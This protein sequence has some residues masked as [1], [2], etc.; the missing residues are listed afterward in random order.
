MRKINQKN[1]EMIIIGVI[2]L[3]AF[4]FGFLSVGILKSFIVIG[5]ADLIYLSTILFNKKKNKPNTYKNNINQ[6]HVKKE[7]K[8]KSKKKIWKIIAIIFLILCIA[9]M[10]MVCGFI[11]YI[12]DN[13]PKFDPEELYTQES[14][15]LYA[16]DGSVIAKL[17]AEKR[18]KVTYDQLPEVLI[19]SIVATEDARFFQH[20]GFDLSR[21]VIAS[22]KQVLTGGGGGA[23]T[24]TMQVSK[25]TYTSTESSGIEG[26]IRKFTDIYLSIFQIEKNYS[27]EEIMEFYVNAPYLGGGSYGVEQACQTYFNKSVS[28]INLAEAAMIAGLFQA[29]NAYDP[30]LHPEATE[31]RRQTVLYLMKRHGYITDEEYEIAK[32]MTVEKLLS[33]STDDESS[34]NDY[35]AFIDTV[36]EEVIDNTGYD[37]A[38][39]PME[40][41]TTLDKDK[42]AAID[43]I[44][45]GESFT[46][47]NEY[48]DAGISVIDVNTGAIVA[49]GAGRNRVGERQYNTATMIN[50]QIGSTAKPLY[51]YAPGIEF[52]NWST[53]TPFI[54]EEY[55]YSNGVS[56]YNWDRKYNGFLSLRT[57]LAQ[58]RNIPALK[59]FQ[60]NKNA[61]IKSFVTSLGLSPEIEDGI[62]HEAHAIGGYNGES[63]L[64]MST[65]FAAFGNGGYYITSHSYTKIV[66]KEDNSVFEPTITKTRVMSEETA[67]MMTSLLQSS[68]STG[69]G[70]QSNVG[71][72]I[73]GAK[74]GTSNYDAATIEKWNFGDNAVNDLWVDGVSPDYAISVWYGYK[75]IVEGYTSTS[76]SIGHRKLFQAVAKS[77]FNKNSSW[78]KPSGVVEVEIENE[79]YPAKLPSEFTPSSMKITELFKS[80]T[81]PTEI[82][83]RYSKLNSV[84]N[85]KG[86]VSDNT[87]TLTWDAIATPNAINEASINTYLD[88]L[89]SSSKFKSEAKAA[90]LSYNA[91]FFGSL[92]YKVYSKD[93]SGNLT[94]L[95][96]TDKTTYSTSVN[97]DS[98]TTYA[99]VASY[100]I[101]TSNASDATEVKI[102][103]S[104]VASIDVSLIG[105]STINLKV[106]SSYS[107]KGVKVT[108][109]STDVT[110][111]STIKT[112]IKNSSGDV[113]TSI[114]TSKADTYVITYA[115]TYKSLSKSITRTIKITQA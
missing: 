7:K 41:Y 24:L 114:D 79:T 98:S 92:I 53:Y 32:A 71:G 38:T 16:A 100:T 36:I 111:S 21:F 88:S 64:S 1:K 13:A 5:M 93:S 46:W 104:N 55:T 78:T 80:G 27:K 99:V 108:S 25:N 77:I 37:P 76:Y 66:Y 49:V 75:K 105:E 8:V 43:A 44:M 34:N 9:F 60:G 112:T 90:K 50:R 59:A 18:E 103:L 22:A 58:S 109:N 10:I 81:E 35:Q 45:S 4:I 96:S 87:L 65:A 82:S 28:D 33:T 12:V 3:I 102:S 51:D 62:V 113:V 31:K 85:L 107:E 86:T 2:S 61:D 39:V 69:L 54:D 47:E 23:S 110:S 15:T 84:S 115:V 73:F 17:G 19:N 56:V 91:S 14:S 94:L 67:Y 63:P 40:I 6:N 52:Q 30:Y 101:F 29:P 20:N 97:S 72:A 70:A 74:T 26:I 48:V 11:F 106:G 89:Y 57:A 83:D 42:Q 95:G 68:A